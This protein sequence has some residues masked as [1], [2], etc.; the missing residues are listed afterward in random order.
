MIQQV[1]HV[2]YGDADAARV[3]V[4]NLVAVGE[5]VAGIII[6]PIQ[7]EA[8]V[9]IPPDGYLKALREIC[10][11]FGICLIFDEIQ[12]GLGRTGTLWRCDY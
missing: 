2:K 11:D 3:A 10:D 5:K 12:T 9:I 4:E 6:E 1:Q 8:G 7:G